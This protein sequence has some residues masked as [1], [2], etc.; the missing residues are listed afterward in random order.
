MQ[1][2]PSVKAGS[3]GESV[4][5]V[6][7]K[8]KTECNQVSS[9]QSRTGGSSWKAPM[10]WLLCLQFATCLAKLSTLSL[11]VA[12]PTTLLFLTCQFQ[13][14]ASL[15][16]LLLLLIWPPVPCLASRSRGIV[17]CRS[18]FESPK[19]LLFQAVSRGGCCL[20]P[21]CFLLSLIIYT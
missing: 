5:F 16:G 4:L 3:Q 10:S 19:R 14:V 20:C 8:D 1:R 12:H 9:H 7:L 6:W 11:D 2:C 18:A 13:T 15:C 21:V 17:R